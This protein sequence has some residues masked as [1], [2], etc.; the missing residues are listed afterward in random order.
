VAILLDLL[1]TQ[2]RLGRSQAL[3]DLYFTAAMR[4]LAEQ[5]GN[6]LLFSEFLKGRRKRKGPALLS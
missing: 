6:L 1:Q 2:R 5:P 4:A 3:L